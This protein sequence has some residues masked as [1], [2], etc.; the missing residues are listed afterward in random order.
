M[1]CKT[2]AYI[3][4]TFCDL[5]NEII[6]NIISYLRWS[7]RQIK[8]KMTCKLMYNL[9]KDSPFDISK[10]MLLKNFGI[11]T[12]RICCANCNCC[13]DTE[14]V[15]YNHYRNGDPYY[16]HNYQLALNKTE[17]KINNKFHTVRTHYCSECFKKY[18]LVGERE[19]VRHNYSWIDEVNIIYD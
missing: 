3:P 9:F 1:I 8:I 14:E 17:I 18:V 15:F 5:P 7:D 6:Q 11:F 4:L 12:F 10:K 19:N 16:I 13:N 2:D